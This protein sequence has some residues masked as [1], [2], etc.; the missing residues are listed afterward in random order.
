MGCVLGLQPSRHDP[1]EAIL[2]VGF[3]SMSECRVETCA[4]LRV[5]LHRFPCVV[6]LI[7]QPAEGAKGDVLLP[8]PPPPYDALTCGPGGPF[9]GSSKVG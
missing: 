1:S 4:V 3:H 6:L 8:L 7:R 2:Q 9:F 5:H